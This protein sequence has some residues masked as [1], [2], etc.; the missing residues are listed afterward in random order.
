M[1]LPSAMEGRWWNDGHF[2]GT[3]AAGCLFTEGILRAQPGKVWRIGYLGYSSPG[4]NPAFEQALRERGY[5]EGSNVLFERRFADGKDEQY[6]APLRLS[7]TAS[8]SRYC[9]ARTR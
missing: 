2:I 8:R 9:C 5:V 6:P 4:M 1:V 7:W 3:V